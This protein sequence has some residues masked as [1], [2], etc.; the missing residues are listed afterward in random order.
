MKHQHLMRRQSMKQY[1]IV[2]IFDSIQG[3]G[4]HIG[5]T[6]TFIRFAGCNLN[7]PWCDTDWKKAK[8]YLSVEDLFSAINPLMSMVVLT[9]GEPF[10]QDLLPLCRLIREKYP[11]KL[12][13][14]ETNGTYSAEALTSKVSNI[15]ITCS[16][17]P[18]NNWEYKCSPNELK[19]VIDDKIT[20]ENINKHFPLVW[21]QP[22][23]YDMDNS[24]KKCMRWAMENPTWRVGV[25]LHKIMEV[26]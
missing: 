17:K 2:E 3:E 7:C 11:T 19:Y 22:Q 4:Y 21:L 20:Q 12:I 23:G 1:P 14:I 24:W 9:G 18:E 16:P 26:R 25:Q 15:W 10:L 13:A 5:K 6:A 8:K